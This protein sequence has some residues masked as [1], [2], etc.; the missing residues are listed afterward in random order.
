MID[1]SSNM[2][3]HIKNL[4][5]QSERITYQMA[6]GKAIDKGSEDS[7]LHA[8]I[9]NVEDKLRV[10]EGLKL[11]LEK[12]RALNN[13]AD[14]NIGEV[15][16][17]LES[18]KI[19]LL[20]SLNDGMDKNDKLALATN[21][22]GIRET[23]LDRVNTQIDGEYLF[24][25]SVTDIPTMTKDSDFD[26]NGKVSFDGDGFLR[27]IAVQPGSYRDRGVTAYDVIFYNA[28]T[29]I[30]GEN[31]TFTENERVIDEAGHEW[32]VN[33]VTNTLQK[34]DLNGNLTSPLDEIAISSSTAAI[35][36]TAT[37]EAVPATYSISPLSIPE[38]SR[39]DAKHNYFDDLNIIINALEGYNTNLD[40]TKGTY[41]GDDGE[42]VDK[43]LNKYLDIT[44]QQYNAT[45]IGHGELGGRNAVFEVSYEK[46]TAQVS[47]YN[48]LLEEIGS[49]D[50]AKLAMESKSLELTYQSLYSTISKMN[51]LSLV[52]FLK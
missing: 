15:K 37:T 13:T 11:Q 7:M 49:A 14:N 21:L 25:G 34:Y 3:Y 45:N 32:K 28:D 20:K 26:L 9:I 12:T 8:R 5:L 27:E 6:S 38:G 24:T 17:A 41:I 39:F 52:N 19:D 51:N 40:G 2:M 50:M 31:F 29:A 42:M 33:T 16:T 43:I 22:T 10:T 47:Q 35:P 18:I 23:I 44:S 48:I 4:N 36:E 30:N 1:M 46:V